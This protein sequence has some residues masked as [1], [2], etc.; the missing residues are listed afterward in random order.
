M[1]KNTAPTLQQVKDEEARLVP[2]AARASELRDAIERVKAEIAQLGEDIRRP[3]DPATRERVRALALGDAPL[4]NVDEPEYLAEQRRQALRQRCAEAEE[5]RRILETALRENGLEQNAVR[6][7]VGAAKGAHFAFLYDVAFAG[8]AMRECRR[9]LVDL[10][11][12][13]CAAGNVTGWWDW[14]AQA[15]TG[16]DPPTDEEHAAAVRRFAGE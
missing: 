13:A 5:R 11:G 12:A 3:H 16:W 9:Q 7:A 14:L 1:S 8:D 2:L 6:T 10:Y 15:V 4:D